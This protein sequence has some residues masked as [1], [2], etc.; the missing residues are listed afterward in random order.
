MAT[1]AGLHNRDLT[2]PPPDLYGKYRH[3]PLMAAGAWLGKRWWPFW[4]RLSSLHT[5]PIDDGVTTVRIIDRAVVAKD[6]N[7]VALTF[8]APDG[9]PLPRW[10]V[11]AH[12]DLLLPSG[13]MREYSL[14]GD[15]A[16]R[17]TYRIAVRRIP[18]GGGGSIE[19]HDDLRVGDEL[20]IKGPRNAF[21]LSMP[22][23]GSSA[24][25]VRFIAAGI[26]I[27]PILPMLA[28]AERHGLDWS[29]IYTGRTLDSIPFVEE[30]SRHGDR[31]TIRADDEHGLPTM[32]ELTGIDPA[33]GRTPAGL[34]VYA[35]GP[36][37]MLAGLRRHLADRGDV[38]LHYERFSPPPVVDGAPFTITLASTGRRVA[39]AAD[40][41]ALAALR[42]VAPSVPYSCRQGFC[43]T[44]RL[45]VLDGEPDHRDT[46]LTAPERADGQFLTCV[47]RCTEGNLT[48]DL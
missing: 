8:A 5:T 11:G 3:D 7:V 46:L 37:P 29:M 41:T 16:D 15:P 28:A 43:G 48:V 32:A 13:R 26:G 31:V 10:Y 30:V 33:T 47:S 27:T 19:V 38:E 22:G 40:E 17:S 4:G 14:C 42:T 35:C 18:G 6:E 12:L 2:A 44:C 1:G 23:Y 21:P 34:A 25:S 24:R 39:V 45:R 9:G 20:R 36:V